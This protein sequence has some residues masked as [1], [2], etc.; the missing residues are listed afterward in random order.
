MALWL[1]KTEPSNWSWEN[2]IKKGIEMWD[3]VRNHQAAKNLKSMAC[4]DRCFFYHSHEKQICGVVEVVKEY[5]MDPTDETGKFVAVDMKTVQPFNKRVS[6]DMIKK[7]PS[8][9]HLSLLKQSRLSVQPVDQKSWDIICHMGDTVI[10][11]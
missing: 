2:Q 10:N 1:V 7:N 3:G 8:L 11:K 5:Y 6:L 9:F 4:G